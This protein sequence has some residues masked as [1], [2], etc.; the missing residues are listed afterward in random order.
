MPSFQKKSPKEPDE[1]IRKRRDLEATK[2]AEVE[3]APPA[4][5]QGITD[6]AGSL[7]QANVLQ[8]QRAVGNQAVEQLLKDRVP[9]QT[10]EAGQ[11]SIQRSAEQEED[12]IDALCPGSKIRSAGLGRGEG[13]G[14]GKG[15]IGYP[16]DEEW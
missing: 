12:L 14:E 7:S 13:T 16:K 5:F 2:G 9:A 1:I 4:A 3:P 15:P 6:G 10:I 8:L 11:Q